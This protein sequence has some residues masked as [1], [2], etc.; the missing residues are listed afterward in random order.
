MA[1]RWRKIIAVRPFHSAL[2]Q[3]ARAKPETPPPKYPRIDRRVTSAPL[4]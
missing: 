3:L 1:K 2:Y 4:L